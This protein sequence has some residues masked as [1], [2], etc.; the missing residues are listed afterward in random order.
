MMSV[1]MDYMGLVEHLDSFYSPV[2]AI[3]I[4]Q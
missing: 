3:S 4:L 2:N 1:M